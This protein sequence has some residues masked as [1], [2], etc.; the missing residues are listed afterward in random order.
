MAKRAPTVIQIPNGSGVGTQPPIQIPLLESS[1]IS[2]VNLS[3]VTLTLCNDDTFNTT[4]PLGPNIT[5]PEP[6]VDNL[7]V[8]NDSGND[9]QILV[10]T[11]D[12]SLT[13]YVASTS[14]GP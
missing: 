9:A 1:I 2:L 8:M 11:Y 6:G 7:W 14:G 10:L 12:A 3:D 4:W 5:Q 13:P